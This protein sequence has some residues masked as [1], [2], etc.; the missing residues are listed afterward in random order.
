MIFVTVGTQDRPFTRLIKAVDE[1]VKLGRIKDEVIVQAGAS[2]YKSEYIKVLNYVP[3]EEFNK[4]INNADII[5]THGGVGSILSA[6]KLGKKVI[7]VP[8]LKKYEEHI[9]NH[10]LQVIEKMTKDGYILST[11]DENMI[12]EKVK[13]IANFIPKVYTS[14][15]EKFV[16]NFKKI[17]DEVIN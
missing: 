5:I 7:A 8:R 1:A 15:T 4:Y 12:A 10:Q 14:N 9:N 16:T 2:E 17:L 11:E 6:I 13:E 3:F